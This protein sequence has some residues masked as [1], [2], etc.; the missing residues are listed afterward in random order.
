MVSGGKSLQFSMDILAGA[1][2]NLWEQSLA[3]G[4]PKRM[5]NFTSGRIFDFDWSADGTRLLMIRGDLN[6]DVV[7][8]RNFR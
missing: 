8:V 6:G 3:G 5:T 1:A 4:Q 2:T 7:L